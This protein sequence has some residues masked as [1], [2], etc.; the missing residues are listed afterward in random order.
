MR[1]LQWMMGRVEGKADGQDNAFGISPRYED[2]QWDGLSFSREQ[3]GAVIGMDHADWQQE[4]KLH[5]ELFKQLAYHLPA[6][7]SAT[8]S[9]IADKLA[10]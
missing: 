7:L 3:F 2:L 10:A 9:R 6:E 5:D 8:K 1:V 4:L